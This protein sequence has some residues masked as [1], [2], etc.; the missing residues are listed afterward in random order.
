[1]KRNLAPDLRR[2]RKLTPVFR[3]PYLVTEVV[4]P[5]LYRIRDRKKSKVVHHDQL[6]VCPD[7]NVPLWMRRLRERFLVSGLVDLDD[8][9]VDFCLD[10]LFEVREEIERSAVEV[11]PASAP[12]QTRRG[13]SVVAPSHLRDFV[14]H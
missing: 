5:I 12:V 10:R 3:G 7:T 11:S 6:A 1:M 8:E 2:N 4:S 13:R 9:V 14:Q